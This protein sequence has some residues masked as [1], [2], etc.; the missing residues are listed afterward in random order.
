[1][2]NKIIKP[3]DEFP[4]GKKVIIFLVLAFLVLLLFK[5]TIDR[6]IVIL[7][8]LVYDVLNTKGTTN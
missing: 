6:S 3:L 8:P 2:L 1:M 7:F 4:L 5:T